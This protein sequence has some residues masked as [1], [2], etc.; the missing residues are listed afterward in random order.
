MIDPGDDTPTAESELWD[1][2]D[3]VHQEFIDEL[4][5]DDYSL[6]ELRRLD[7]R[8][9]ELI[10]ELEEEGEVQSGESWPLSLPAEESWENWRRKLRS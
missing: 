5:K 10:R 2:L 1:E 8:S 3:R 4:A 9:A 6:E 7:A